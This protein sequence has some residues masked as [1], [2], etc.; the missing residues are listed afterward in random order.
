MGNEKVSIL[1]SIHATA[2]WDWVPWYQFIL[3]QLLIPWI[4]DTGTISG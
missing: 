4:W 3:Y 2:C 1:G